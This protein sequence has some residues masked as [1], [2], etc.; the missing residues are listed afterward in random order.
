VVGAASLSIF[1]Y[2]NG[3]KAL[4]LA[5]KKIMYALKIATPYHD[6]NHIVDENE[7]E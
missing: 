3:V 6:F 7:A 1:C 4:A 5:T 2:D